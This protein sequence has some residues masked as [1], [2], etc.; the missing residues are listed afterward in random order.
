MGQQNDT[1]RG[2]SVSSAFDYMET[3]ANT[4]LTTASS[5]QTIASSINATVNSTK[6]ISES[7]EKQSEITQKLLKELIDEVKDLRE[8]GDRAQEQIDTL[9][10]RVQELEKELEDIKKE[11]QERLIDPSTVPTPYK[12]YPVSPWFDNPTPLTLDPNRVWCKTTYDE[13]GKENGHVAMIS[14]CKNK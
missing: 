12:P 7:Y 10:K 5:A 13:N 14:T 6:Y 11:K 2:M 1:W 4:A 8:E 3:K 9:A